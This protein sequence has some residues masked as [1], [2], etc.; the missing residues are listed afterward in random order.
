[1]AAEDIQN[2]VDDLRANGADQAQRLKAS[3]R[4]ASQQAEQAVRD[5]ADDLRARADDL[6]ARAR[7]YYEDA[8]DRLE[9]AQRYLVEQVQ[10]KPVA[11]TL[12]AVGVGL[13]L[14]LLLAGGRRR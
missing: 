12:T 14:G 2:A 1:M 5:S 4:E 6:R 11:A 7:D 13:V 8:S 3:V 9:S 10:E